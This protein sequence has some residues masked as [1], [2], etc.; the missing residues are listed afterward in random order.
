MAIDPTRRHV[1]ILSFALCA[2]ACR[3]TEPD[4][5]VYTE[6][7]PPHLSSAIRTADPHAASQLVSGWHQVED[8]AWRWTA[9][10]FSAVLRPPPGSGKFGAILTLHLT[11]PDVVIARLGSTTLSASVAGLRL[12]PETYAHSGVA[13]YVREIPPSILSG[14]SVR[15]DFALDRAIPPKSIDARDSRELGVIVGGL[16]LQTK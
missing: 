6:E 5:S 1:L 4:L 11:V 7:E 2:A 13:R 3:R 16:D 8:N 15:V 12:A 14:D 9:R 10:S